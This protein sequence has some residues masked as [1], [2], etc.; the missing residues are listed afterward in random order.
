MRDSKLWLVAAANLGVIK[1]EGD[2]RRSFP[3]HYKHSGFVKRAHRKGS[4]MQEGIE[5]RSPESLGRCDA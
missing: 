3:T 1:Q 2:E 4:V 5:D